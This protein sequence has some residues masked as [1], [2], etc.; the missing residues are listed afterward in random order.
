MRVLILSMTVGQGHNAAGL[1]LK[2]RL[3]KN[4]HDC[5]ILDTYKYLSKPIGLGID[6]GYMFMG[7]F[8]PQLNKSIFNSAT[9]CNGRA[10]MKMYFPWVFADLSKVKMKKYIDDYKPDVIVC[11]I[12]MT[13]ILVTLMKNANMLD[14]KTKLLGLVTDYT[15][16]PFWEHTDMDYFVCP[17]ELMI[18]SLCGRG[19]KKEKIL[20]VGIPIDETFSYIYSKEELREKL[21]LH[22]HLLTVMMSAG[23]M[24]FLGLVS[25]IEEIDSEENIQI[26]AICGTNKGLYNK[27]N[28][29][30]F[31]NKVHVLGFVNNMAEYMAASDMVVTKPGGVSTSEA[32]ALQK[33]LLLSNPVPGI[34]DVNLAFLLNHSLAIHSNKYYSI[35]EVVVQMRNNESKLEEMRRAQAK[36]GKKDSAKILSDFIENMV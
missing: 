11:S 29:M 14:K 16:H 22:K 34:E 21:G 24:G 15:L 3:L 1:A 33:P 30:T 18:E 5:E 26:V 17:N 12:V 10:D 20:P 4:G 28:K 31:K 35:S 7:R 13:A 8:I 27:I 32:I 19:I 23:G 36:W 6:K 9:K 25:A 2:K